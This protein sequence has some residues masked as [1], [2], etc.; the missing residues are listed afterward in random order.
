MSVKIVNLGSP[1]RWLAEA[2]LLARAHPRVLFGAA[3]YLLLVALLPTL[4]QLMAG[5][6]IQSS[7]MV[8]TV[9][10]VVFT[11]TALVVLPPMTGGLYRL[12]HE[13]H[14]GRPGKASDV[15]AVFQ[16]GS[17][18]R[19]LILS[20][21][22]FMLVMIVAIV[23]L[24]FAFGGQELLGYFSAISA[25]KP[26][27]TELP[28]VP[29]GLLPLIGVM[30]LLMVLINTAKELAT[31]QVALAGRDPATA[32]GQGFKAAALNFGALLLFF[33]PVAIL[34]FIAATVLVLV[35]ALLATALTM[36][37]PMIAALLIM[38]VSLAIGLV[39][40]SLIFVFF[41]QAWLD[42]LAEGESTLAAAPEHQ[43]E[44]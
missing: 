43:I 12:V 24:A 23:G 1:F 14:H 19:R 22:A 16:E 41:Y 34:A 8:R 28:P 36:L 37:H 4:L 11:L 10:Q 21:L 27:T 20:N 17:A 40:Y 2:V 35:L 3:A 15:F 39:A 25:L 26:G 6:A 31:M 9:L 18:T 29:P 44:V 30:G 5:S 33:V 7:V 32:I 38:P 13:L 42:T